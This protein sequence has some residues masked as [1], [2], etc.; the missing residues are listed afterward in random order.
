MGEGKR[1]NIDEEKVPEWAMYKDVGITADKETGTAERKN[2]VENMPKVG[3]FGF[4]II[5]RGY[6]DEN[7]FGE[8]YQ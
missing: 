1:G 4:L 2:D 8:C 3:E 7:H 5:F 6:Q